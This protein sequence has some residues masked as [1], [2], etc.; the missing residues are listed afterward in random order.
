MKEVDEYSFPL[1]MDQSS[2]PMIWVRLRDVKNLANINGPPFLEYLLQHKTFVG[3]E[4]CERSSQEED[5]V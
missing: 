1:K 4:P 2:P 3:R 5:F